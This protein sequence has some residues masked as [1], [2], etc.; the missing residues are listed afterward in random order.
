MALLEDLEKDAERESMLPLTEDGKER[1]NPSRP[2]TARAKV[3]D[4]ACILLNIS[5]TVLLVF[6]NNWYVLKAFRFAAT[7]NVPA[8]S[9]NQPV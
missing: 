9:C 8:I 3:A 1:H 6:L 4:V 2:K 5:S 7:S